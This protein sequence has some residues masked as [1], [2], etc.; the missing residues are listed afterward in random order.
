MLEVLGPEYEAGDV[1][2]QSDFNERQL[3]VCEPA[4]P[5]EMA[6][7][8]N[9]GWRSVGVTRE[10]HVLIPYTVPQQWAMRIHEAEYAGL[11]SQAR[12]DLRADEYTVALFG[13]VG[14]QTSDPHFTDDGGGPFSAV[15]LA[16]FVDDTGIQIAPSKPPMNA[17]DVIS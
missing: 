12:H 17:F 8:L 11:K 14:A 13:P 9:N 10:I 6:D 2:S 4:A 5:L 3:Y 7:L 15:Q 1:V 16:A